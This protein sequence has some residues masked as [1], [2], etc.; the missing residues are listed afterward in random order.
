MVLSMHG[1][2][3]AKNSSGLRRRDTISFGRRWP[4]L[5]SLNGIVSSTLRLGSKTL[6][7]IYVSYQESICVAQRKGT[8]QYHSEID[9][10]HILAG[11][12]R[13]EQLHTLISF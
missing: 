11:L 13:A 8:V 1:K 6:N 10:E 5:A 12:I 9:T 4:G 2:I 3:K 7:S